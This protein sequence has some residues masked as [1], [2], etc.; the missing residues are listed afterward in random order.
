MVDNIFQIANQDTIYA[1]KGTVL[2]REGEVGSNAYL[3][4]EGRL[5]VERE[6]DGK[7]IIIGNISPVDIVGELAILDE[8]PRSA[9][10]KVAEDARLIELN[11]HRMKTIIRRYPDIAEVVMKLLCSKLRKTASK[12]V[13]SEIRYTN[14]REYF[15]TQQNNVEV[16][17]QF[18]VESN[19]FSTTITEKTT[20]T[21]KEESPEKS[22]DSLDK[23]SQPVEKDKA[24]R[25][26][27]IQRRDQK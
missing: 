26:A 3:V 27:T 4:L 20:D 1:A 6:M 8:M 25:M 18:Q 14:L 9:T 7:R 19:S 22:G 17:S 13:D 24:N 21:P 11:K 12:Y 15:C 5:T 23:Y 10:V 16:E 2:M